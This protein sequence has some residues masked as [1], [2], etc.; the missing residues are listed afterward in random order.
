[1]G[2]CAL[3]AISKDHPGCC[4]EDRLRGKGRSWE[5]NPEAVTK[6]PGRNDGVFDQEMRGGHSLDT[7]DRWTG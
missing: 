1:M 3:A 5:T 7:F 2:L 6:I 4:F